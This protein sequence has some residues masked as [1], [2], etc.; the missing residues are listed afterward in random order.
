MPLSTGKHFY[1]PRYGTIRPEELCFRGLKIVIT[2]PDFLIIYWFLT[3]NAQVCRFQV[4]FVAVPAGPGA[5]VSVPVVLKGVSV[6]IIVPRTIVHEDVPFCFKMCLVVTLYIRDIISKHSW[7]VV[8]FY[9][10]TLNRVKPRFITPRFTA[11]LSLRG[12][13]HLLSPE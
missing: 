6:N 4:K 8:K 10:R 11:N 3:N 13:G 5:N 7:S 1:S 2:D 9:H 12:R